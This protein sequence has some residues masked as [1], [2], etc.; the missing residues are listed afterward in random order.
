MDYRL[1]QHAFD[2]E[3]RSGKIW[4][5]ETVE[6]QGLGVG[7]GLESA[8]AQA[9]GAL[10]ELTNF[11]LNYGYSRFNL[12]AR[13]NPDGSETCEHADQHIHQC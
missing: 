4:R 8:P 6:N 12:P 5:E 11:Y 10:C 1:L 9:A 2:T 7:V 3:V 13:A